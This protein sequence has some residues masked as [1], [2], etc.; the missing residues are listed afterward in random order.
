MDKTAPHIIFVLV[1]VAII[2]AVDVL[3]FRH[4][5][6]QRLIANIVIV[7]AFVAFYLVFLKR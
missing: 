4:R 1:M 3:F 6:W 7:L 5:F 2:V